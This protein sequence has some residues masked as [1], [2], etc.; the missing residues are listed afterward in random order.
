MLPSKRK[1]TIGL[2]HAIDGL[3]FV[4]RTQTNFGLHIFVSFLVCI[5][6]L[7]LNLSTQEWLILVLTVSFVLTVE[8]FNT[9]IEVWVDSGILEPNIYAKRVKDSAAAAVVVSSIGS[10]FIGL[11]IFLPKLIVLF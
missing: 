1:Y 9:A 11:I 6:G 10:V 8:I 4:L 2:S 5:L 7:L 3:K